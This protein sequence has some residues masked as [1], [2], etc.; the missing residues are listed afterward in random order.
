M[1]DEVKKTAAPKAEEKAAVVADPNV[2]TDEDKAIL[3]AKAKEKVAKELRQ[4]ALK[5][6]ME[7]I[8]EEV[9]V[10]A[11]LAPKEGEAPTPEE[12]LQHI[13]ISL[14]PFCIDG[15]NLD[16]RKYLHGHTYRVSPSVY[17]SLIDQQQMSWQHEDQKDGKF[18]NFNR[19]ERDT[20]IRHGA[21]VNA[22]MTLNSR[23]D[24][25]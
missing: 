13:V 8:E 23:T 20:H 24:L 3:R 1:T 6:A 25:H 7:E 10:A 22:P 4:A 18:T 2:I 21:A 17:A 9:R 14:P 5:I 15:I 16:G 19:R 11:G 12:L